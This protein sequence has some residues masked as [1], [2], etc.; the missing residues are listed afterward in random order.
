MGR[1]KVWYAV[2]Q[3]H[4]IVNLPNDVA[5]LAVIKAALRPSAKP[6]YAEGVKRVTREQIRSWAMGFDEDIDDN[7][8]RLTEIFKNL[9]I[10]EKR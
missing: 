3:E 6:S 5:A 10:G 7:E 4:H 2:A 1:V 8:R 9:G